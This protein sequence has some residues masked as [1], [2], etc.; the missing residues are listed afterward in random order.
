ML[1]LRV[2][3]HGLRLIILRESW[4]MVFVALLSDLHIHLLF[5]FLVSY[6]ASSVATP[7]LVVI[8]LVFIMDELQLDSHLLPMDI[9]VM[10]S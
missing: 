9:E 8:F 6:F 2:S 10:R 5:L 1:L 7:P 4:E 3:E